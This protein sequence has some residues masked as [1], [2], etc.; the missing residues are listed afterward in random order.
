M[1][2]SAASCKMT[3]ELMLI[4]AIERLGVAYHFQ[5]YIEKRL[6]EMMYGNFKSD[7]QHDLFTTSTSFR[8]FRQ[9][10][11]NISSGKPSTVNISVY[12]TYVLQ[13]CMLWGCLET[14]T[15]LMCGV[16]T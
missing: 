16:R 7:Q 9:H 6:G 14:D 3:E 2:V 13:L 11:Y 4:N 15:I 8:I 5:D 12:N 1:L 10:G